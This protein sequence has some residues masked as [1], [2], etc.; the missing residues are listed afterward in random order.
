MVTFSF[1][2]SHCHFNLIDENNEVAQSLPLQ[3]SQDVEVTTHGL[4]INTLIHIICDISITSF[5]WHKRCGQVT[6]ACQT[7]PSYL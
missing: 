1:Q 7:C 5:D 6:K 2:L 3:L 4:Y